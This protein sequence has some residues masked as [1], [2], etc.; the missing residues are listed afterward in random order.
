MKI[1]LCNSSASLKFLRARVFDLQNRRGKHSTL[2]GT[3]ADSLGS[4]VLVSPS[5]C[6]GNDACNASTPIKFL[7]ARAFDIQ[8]CICM[9][10]VWDEC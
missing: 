9:H 5:A 2:P 1:Y 10:I 8:N 4:V 7:R 6:K 3:N